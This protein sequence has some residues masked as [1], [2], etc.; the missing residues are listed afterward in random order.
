M[1]FHCTDIQFKRTDTFARK[2]SATC[3]QIK[4]KN[5]CIIKFDFCIRGCRVCEYSKTKKNILNS[6]P[7]SS[8]TLPLLNQVLL[9][10]VGLLLGLALGQSILMKWHVMEARPTW[11]TVQLT[12]W[13]CTTVGILKMPVSVAKVWL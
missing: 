11:P 13:V 8:F 7:N 12:I 10:L 1:G 2:L 5:V 4:K 6:T 9:H 3:I